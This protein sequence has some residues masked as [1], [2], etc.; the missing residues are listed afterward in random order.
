MEWESGETGRELGMLLQEKYEQLIL[1]YGFETDIN[2]ENVNGMLRDVLTVFLSECRTPAIWCYGEHTRM[3]MSDFMNELKSVKFIIDRHAGDYAEDSGFKV[4]YSS[5]IE[6][7]GI[8]GVI[9]S[10]YKLRNEIKAQIEAEHPC[11]KY[12]DI[13]DYFEQNG[14]FVRKEYYLS[15]HPYSKYSTINR[16]KYL[17]KSEEDGDK[18]E[19]LLLELIKSFVDIKDFLLAA[20]CADA[21]N[22]MNGSRKNIKLLGQLRELY[23]LECRAAEQIGEDNVLMLCFDGMRDKDIYSGDMPRFDDFVHNHCYRYANGYSVSTSTYESLV[24]AYGE[25]AD[26]RTKYYE[27]N[28]VKEDECRFIRKAKQQGR[29][30]Y[31]YTDFAKYIDDAGIKRKQLYQTATE[32]LWD[33]IADASEKT[34]GLFYVHIL[35]E[36]HYSYP[37]PYIDEGIVA[38]GSHIM[39]D[40]LYKNGGGIRADY[41]EQHRNSLKYL[42]DVL[43]SV[44][45]RIKCRMFIFAD[46]G[47][48]IFN[49]QMRLEDFEPLHFT[50]HDDLIH[51]P[52]IIKSPEMP[53]GVDNR[54]ISLMEI[55][56][57]LVC[58]MEKKK[59][60]AKQP[61]VVKTQRSAI[62]NPDFQYLYKKCG[63]EQ[64]LCAFEAFIFEDHSSL[65]IYGNGYTELSEQ[66]ILVEDDEKKQVLFE[67]IKDRVTVCSLDKVIISS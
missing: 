3:L 11:V 7:Y 27:N 42:E 51:I 32:K 39:F 63:Q 37:N 35:Y 24:P 48:I 4:L 52:F 9:I 45:K 5:E 26:M 6:E 44:L 50:Y 61:A 14:V 67:Q 46:H 29:E 1:E 23:D 47:N 55:N 18:K 25:N 12:L 59:F 36:S 13:Y 16:L 65:A 40:F 21:L 31:F 64:G 15:T 22:K 62:Y 28:C 41:V 60:I 58:L 30:I 20:K 10:S 38:E 53:V 49:R 66:G 54:N 8:D 17:I 2:T 19:E 33:F 57:I 56:E 34:N 43:V